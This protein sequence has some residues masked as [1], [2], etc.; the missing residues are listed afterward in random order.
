[1]TSNTNLVNLITALIKNKEK[2]KSLGWQQDTEN[3]ETFSAKLKSGTISTWS[4]REE[5]NDYFIG[6]YSPSGQFLDAISDREFRRYSRNAFSEMEE[7]YRLA[8]ASALGIDR[9]VQGMLD[10]LGLMNLD[11]EAALEDEIPF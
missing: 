4:S 3:K 11:D 1:M 7:L 9:T 5:S 6:L 2:F 8:R 10:E